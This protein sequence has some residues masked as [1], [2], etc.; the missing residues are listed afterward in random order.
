MTCLHNQCSTFYSFQSVLVSSICLFRPVCQQSCFYSRR[1][2]EC[3]GF[4][5]V[6]PPLHSSA[7]PLF[8]SQGL[9]MSCKKKKKKKK[10]RWTPA[11]H[12]P[13][14]REIAITG[15]AF[16]FF[17]PPHTH[18][19]RRQIKEGALNYFCEVFWSH[20]QERRWNC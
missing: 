17:P 2:S 3:F 4:S 14:L 11:V 20:Y 8:C 15:S 19:R 1:H 12:L 9:L 16:P 6:S 13:H 10:H 7:S 18:A 5:P